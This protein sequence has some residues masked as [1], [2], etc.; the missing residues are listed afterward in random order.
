[1]IGTKIYAEIITVI[2]ITKA[3]INRPYADV[4]TAC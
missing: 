3:F 1:V 2:K 4:F